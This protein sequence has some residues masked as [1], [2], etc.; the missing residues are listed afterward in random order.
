M[1]SKS[2]KALLSS[3]WNEC[4]APC[5]PF[6]AFVQHYPQHATE[7]DRIFRQYTGNAITLGQAARQ[8]EALVPQG[9]SAAQMDAYLKRHFRTY[10]GVTRLMRWCR[11]NGVLLMINTTGMIGYFQRLSAM[12]LLPQLP[13]LS[14]HGLVRF[15]PLPSDPETILPLVETDDKAVHT[16]AVAGRYGIAP[17]CTFVMGDSGGDGPHFRWGA[18]VGACLI[19]SMA[20]PSLLSYCRKHDIAIDHFFGHTYSPEEEKSPEKELGYDFM[21][22]CAIIEAAL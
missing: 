16:A 22:L 12:G 7:L 8:I 18:G 14:A 10:S 21:T 20:K 9:I 3:D 13:V 2:F 19:A 4:L 17:R 6:D 11:D 5:G 15:A 1:K